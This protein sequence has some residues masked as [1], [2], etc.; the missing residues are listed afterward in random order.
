MNFTVMEGFINPHISCFYSFFQCFPPL[1]GSTFQIGYS[2]VLLFSQ[3]RIGKSQ[4]KDWEQRGD[5]PA[6]KARKIEWMRN[7]EEEAVRGPYNRCSRLRHGK[8]TGRKVTQGKKTM[9]GRF[10]CIA[11][12]MS[13]QVPRDNREAWWHLVVVLSFLSWCNTVTW[14]HW[15]TS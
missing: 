4:C 5:V 8:G 14:Q 13:M 12:Q 7:R 2:G 15:D 3:T 11:N 9:K 10:L 1:K 6:R